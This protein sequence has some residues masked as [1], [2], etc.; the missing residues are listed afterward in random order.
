MTQF[1]A[2]KEKTYQSFHSPY[3][4]VLMLTWEFPP[5]IVGGLSKH[6]FGL[7]KQFS[8][9]GAEVHVITAGAFGL[10]DYEL[11]N[12]IHV[13]RVKP[14]NDQDDDFLSWIGGL[15]LAMAFKAMEL[16]TTIGFSIIHAHDWLV[17]AA[18]AVLKETLKLPLLTTIHATESGRNNGIHNEMQQ[19]I[20]EKEKQLT[21][22]SDQLIVCSDYMKLELVSVFKTLKEKIIVI[23]NGIEPEG[24]IKEID[25]GMFPAPKDKKWIFSVG[26]TVKE[27]GFETIIEAASIAKEIELNVFFV[28]AGKGPM[29]Q[30]YRR[31]V[32]ERNLTD[33]ITFI[34]YI[35]EEEKN[36][37]M[38]ASEA[39]VFPSMYEPFG[40]VALESMIKGKPTVV[41]NEGGLRGI[42]KHE[43]SG[44]FMI[45]GDAES[46][47]EQIC[48]LLKNPKKAQEIGEM[49]RRIVKSLYGWN[50]IAADTRRIMED[51]ILMTQLSEEK[52]NG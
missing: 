8:Q 34:G 25:P 22:S 20:H 6:V 50:R 23:P 38:S 4:K 16:G 42:V 49:G 14:L 41:S 5:N 36:A 12:D 1:I 24:K 21:E 43:Q 45:P 40:I 29:L 26:R 13:H 10:S 30:Y 35:P 7:S 37:W 28:I 39:N 47:I 3:L 15:N 27:K 46:L 2:S 51:L 11:M 52:I 32:Q 18:A 9:S 33:Y 19:F 31:E 17:G 48:Y 44:L